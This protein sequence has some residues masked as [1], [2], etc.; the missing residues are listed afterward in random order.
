MSLLDKKFVDEVV[1][2]ECL[3]RLL[4]EHISH[5]QSL[6][7]EYPSA[8]IDTAYTLSVRRE[9]TEEEHL[10]RMAE[11]KLSVQNTLAWYKEQVEKY[12]KKLQEVY[13]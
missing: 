2:D 4:S 8:I 13:Q 5:L 7:K 1:E 10:K 12:S 9:E 3:E 6:L 11:E